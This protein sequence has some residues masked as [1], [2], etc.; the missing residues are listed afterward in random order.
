MVDSLPRDVVIGKSD[1]VVIAS[2]TSEHL[3]DIHEC[4]VMKRP[5]FVE[6][7]IADGKIDIKATTLK[8][9][10]YPL[11][12]G[13]NLRFHPCVL[14]AKEWLDDGRIG[15]PYWAS[16]TCAQFNDRPEY[17]RDGVTLNW[18]HEIDLALYL[19]GKAE[20]TG[21]AITKNDDIADILLRH[22]V[23]GAQTTIH[24]DYVSRPEQRGFS[25]AGPGGVIIVN[26]PNRNITLIDQEGNLKQ[27]EQ[28]PGSY[29]TDYITE[30]S[31]FVARVEGS[32]NPILGCTAEE[33]IEVLKVCLK[34]K[35]VAKI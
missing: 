1:A 8:S 34:A 24:L 4:E 33:A 14:K 21:A 16:I 6:K 3:D 13:Y 31:A 29:D 15:N 27:G 23:S 18:S 11:M 28:F 7:P 12:V 9:Y 35:K 22:S 10:K 32:G 30:M 5:C 26:I 19:L 25:I 20:V 2:P 17:L